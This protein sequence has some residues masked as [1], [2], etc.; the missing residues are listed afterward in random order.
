MDKLRKQIDEIDSQIIK[1]L[2]AR[3]SITAQVGEYK[4]AHHLPIYDQKREQLILNKISDKINNDLQYIL[5]I[6]QEI[7]KESKKQQGDVIDESS[8]SK[9]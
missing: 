5:P 3:F 8:N 2:E 9:S 7:L 4:K 1:L 6:Y